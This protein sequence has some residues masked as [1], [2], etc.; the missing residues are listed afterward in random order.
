MPIK[1]VFVNSAGERVHECWHN[2]HPYYELNLRKVARK[3]LKNGYVIIGFTIGGKYSEED[4]FLKA[5]NSKN[6]GNVKNRDVIVV[7]VEQ[8]AT[9]EPDANVPAPSD[10]S[11]EVRRWRLRFS[12]RRNH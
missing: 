12:L 5:G 6:R 9:G 8:V 11:A 3:I 2:L 7:T 1:L 10:R 4:V